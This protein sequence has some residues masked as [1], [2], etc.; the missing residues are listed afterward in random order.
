VR[1]Q[2]GSDDRPSWG[3]LRVSRR[4]T[5]PMGL[6]GA[7]S[8]VALIVAGCGG[9]E[10]RVA[11]VSGQDGS[12][13][14][15]TA[16][17]APGDDVTVYLEGVRKWV[18][19]L[20]DHGVDVSDPD[21]TGQVTFPGDPALLKTDPTMVAAQESCSSIL[22]AIPESVLELR[23]PKLS[24]EQIEVRRQYAACMQRN[25][26]PDFPDPGVDGYTPRDRPW[27]ETSAGAQ[28]AARTCASVIGDPETP[29]PGRG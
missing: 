3:T 6:I 28:Q 5:R 25:G 9:T 11:S 17:G 21:P 18:G 4:L 22:P 8:V 19:C 1:L 24:A 16:A 14:T 7:T 15:S 10:P 12:G 2:V 26:A 13:T 27:N 23:K 29:V 20:R